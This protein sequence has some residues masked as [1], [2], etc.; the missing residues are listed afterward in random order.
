MRGVFALSSSLQADPPWSPDSGVTTLQDVAEVDDGMMGDRRWNLGEKKGGLGRRWKVCGT[1]PKQSQS[2]GSR[3][4]LKVPHAARVQ[5]FIF[6]SG[7]MWS[8]KQHI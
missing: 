7:L 5:I 2:G 8:R 3:L 1:C 6:H 4:E